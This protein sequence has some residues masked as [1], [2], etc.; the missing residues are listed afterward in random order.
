MPKPYESEY[1]LFM[2]EWLKRHPEERE[3]QRTGRALWWD[4]PQDAEARRAFEAAQAPVR[5]YY[6]DNFH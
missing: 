1:T 5:P 2:R 3:V 6:Y 4:K